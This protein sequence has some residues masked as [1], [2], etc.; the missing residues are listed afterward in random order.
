LLRP[1]CE[2]LALSVLACHDTQYGWL[3]THELD[4][5]SHDDWIDDVVEVTRKATLDAWVA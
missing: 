1:R 3:V 5:L 4:A 2:G